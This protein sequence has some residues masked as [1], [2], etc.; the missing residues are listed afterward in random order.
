MQK[1]FADSALIAKGWQKNVAISIE[2]GSITA[3]DE[4]AYDVNPQ[5]TGAHYKVLVSGMPNLHS[6]AFQRAMAGYTERRGATPDSFWSWRNEMYRLALAMN[7]DEVEAVASQLYIE[8]LEAGFTR[9][10]EFHYLHHDIDGKPYSDIGEMAGRICNAAQKSGIHLTL[11]PVFYAH[12]GFGG[13]TPVDGQKRFI[14]DTASF[15][16]LVQSCRSH[17]KNLEKSIVGIAP[18]S[19]RAATED[20]LK[21][22]L[23]L[24]DGNPIHIHIAEQLKEVD[25]CVAWSGERP[26]EWLLNRFKVNE[27]WCLIHATHLTED[28][29]VNIAKSGAIAGLCPLTEG[30]LGDGIFNAL[31]FMEHGGRFGIGSDSN[32]N[33]SVADELSQFEYSVRLKTHM[34]NAIAKPLG[35]NGR[36][37][38]DEA[39][40]GGDQALRSQSAIKCGN[41]ADFVALDL[42]GQDWIKEDAILDNWIFARTVDV[43]STWVNGVE[44]VR[45]GKHIARDEIFKT[46]SK[47]MNK[48]FG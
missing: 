2:N 29:T 43:K 40:K 20:E 15:A 42:K 13:Q 44:V 23:P 4:N 22:I 39:V 34:R 48:L 35:S 9:V 12:A 21:E 8:M 1:I 38:F 27:N 45:D 32:V 19:L 11:L 31:P 26:V 10:G 33:I 25:D 37:L 36:H 6:H 41:S 17:A 7:P 30:N 14:N 46:Y 3:I 28:E 24:A 16:K 47:T 18:H 5:Q